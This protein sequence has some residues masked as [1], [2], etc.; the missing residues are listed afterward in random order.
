VERVVVSKSVGDV[1][2]NSARKAA[3]G[4]SFNSS[5][6]KSVM[7]RKKEKPKRAWKD[8]FEERK[9][10]RDANSARKTDG[11]AH[12]TTHYSVDELI[13]ENAK[14]RDTPMV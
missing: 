12:N 13:G 6:L 8:W 2:F 4:D 11:D 10:K 9:Q 1:A 7:S 5:L 14:R 3:W